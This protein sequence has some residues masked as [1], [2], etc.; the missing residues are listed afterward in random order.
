M[1]VVNFQANGAT[2]PWR[3]GLLQDGRVHPV[4]DPQGPGAASD[5]A[6]S[7]AL[8]ARSGRTVSAGE[9]AS[10]TDIRIGA[11]VLQPGKIVAAAGNYLDHVS[12]MADGRHPPKTI[13]QQGFF[14]KAPSS[15]LPPGGR[16]LLPFPGRRTDY[17]GELAAVI[18]ETVSRASEREA[19]EAVLGYTCLLDISLR[20][21]EDRG[22]RKSFDTFTPLGP[23]L[24]T[25]DEITNMA[26]LELRTTVNGELRQH[27]SFSQMIL[28]VGALIAGI[29]DVM[30]LYPGDI[31]ATGTPR[32]V[33]PLSPGDHVDV[34]ITGIGTL[35]VDVQARP[36][37]VSAASGP[38]A[39]HAE[40]TH[41]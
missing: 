10:A 13:H 17:E 11:P 16:V 3:A 29:S 24:V 8:A 4:T 23:A 26:S 7:V 20:G 36:A 1:R 38:Q 30:T 15:L 28:D 32:G 33:G 2:G 5:P 27:A 34:E 9:P 41:P 21:D 12:E 31:I 18:G 6:L 14:L 37:P 25:A 22:Y 19:W 39:A 40:R 35:T